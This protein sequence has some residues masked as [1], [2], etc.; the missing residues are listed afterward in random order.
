M[1]KVA[2]TGATGFIGRHLVKELESLGFEV[3]DD[4]TVSRVYHLACP[5]TTEK[6]NADPIRVMDTIMDYTRTVIN[7]WPHALIINASSYGAKYID[8]TAQGAYNV[9]KRCMEVYLVHSGVNHLNYRIP[10]VYGK[11]MDPDGFVRRCAEGRAYYPPDP[12]RMHSIAYI[13]D[14]VHAMARLKPIPTEDITLGQIYELF[15][16]GR[17][18]LHRPTPDSGS[19]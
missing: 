7:T 18:G 3:C 8:D 5:A 17:R 10:S 12:A 19:L 15:N 13:D 14:V 9:A 11:D 1:E 16:S 4:S 2:V 6:I